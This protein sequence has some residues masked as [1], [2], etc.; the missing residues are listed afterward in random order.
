MILIVADTGPVNYLIQIGAIGLLGRLAEKT[1]L[2]ASVQAELLHQAAPEAVRAW[3]AAPP[4]WV[5]IRRATQ[6]IEGEDVSPA[7]REAIALA[8]EPGAAILLMDDRKGHDAQ[9]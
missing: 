9:Q 3:A 1:M 6:P 4:P 2:P 8:K 7:D 5:E